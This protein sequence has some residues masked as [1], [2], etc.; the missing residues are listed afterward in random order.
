MLVG[1]A[2]SVEDL[3]ESIKSYTFHFKTLKIK[4][5]VDTTENKYIKLII[6]GM[7]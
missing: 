5:S 4:C 2:R 7:Q 6:K 3:E 1:L